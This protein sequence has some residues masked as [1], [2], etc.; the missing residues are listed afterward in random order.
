MA[1]AKV[2]QAKL[3]DETDLILQKLKSK[4]LKSFFV[5]QA[6]VFFSQTDKGQMFLHEDGVQVSAKLETKDETK[7]VVPKVINPGQMREW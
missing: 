6:I 7:Q 3:E 5:N 1:K 4:T 2:L